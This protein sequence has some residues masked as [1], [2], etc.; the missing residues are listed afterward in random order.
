MSDV[1]IRLGIFAAIFLAMA[2]WELARP[3]RVPVAGKGRRWFTNLTIVAIDTL[4]VRLVFPLAAVGFAISAEEAGIGLF[5]RIQAPGWLAGII[6][7]VALDLAIY[8]QHVAFHRVPLLWRIHRVHHAD[9]D[10]DV[11]TGL[12]FHPLEIMLSMLWKAAVIALIGAPALAVFVFEAA[13]NGSSVFNHAN[14][15]LPLGLDRVLR[16]FVVTPDMHRVHHSVIRGETDSN[17][18][19]NLSLWDRM[20][21]TYVPQPAEGHERMRTGLEAYGDERPSRLGW[22]L[23]LPFLRD[24]PR[25]Q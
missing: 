19:F 23:L 15:R 3:R 14:A 18:G 17:Y 24:R 6:A 9:R 20:F 7:F 10:V 2:G 1:A 16:L 25:D 5:N 22:S 8:A 12:R 21:S 11:T 13:L 4:A